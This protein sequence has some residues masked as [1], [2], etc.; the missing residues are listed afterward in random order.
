MNCR[1][2]PQY[3]S[4]VLHLSCH[5]CLNTIQT[6]CRSQD[7]L[8]RL[9]VSA[10][11]VKAVSFELLSPGS[12]AA[13]VKKYPLVVLSGY[14]GRAGRTRKKRPIVLAWARRTAR[15]R[16]AKAV[17]PKSVGVAFLKMTSPQFGV[18]FRNQDPSEEPAYYIDL[19]TRREWKKAGRVISMHNGR[20]VRLFDEEPKTE[21]EEF[22]GWDIVPKL[23]TSALR[24]GRCGQNIAD[25][26]IPYV[27]EGHLQMPNIRESTDQAGAL[28]LIAGES[29]TNK[30]YGFRRVNLS[31][32]NA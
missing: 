20:S 19:E 25:Y 12:P 23:R 2:T 32:Q 18:Y 30:A 8:R 11:G 5:L 3:K 4:Q 1:I 22:A 14:R 29:V 24:R 26:P 17:T 31:P 6:G 7:G 9:E 21:I 15:T 16:Q 28:E 27:F 10:G 13:F